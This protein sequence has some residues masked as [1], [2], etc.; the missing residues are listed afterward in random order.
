VVLPA[1]G[2]TP[3]LAGIAW[4]YFTYKPSDSDFD[5]VL[6]SSNPMDIF[7]NP[8]ASVETNEFNNALQ[9]KKQSRFILRSKALPS[10]RGGF[11]VALRVNGA[12]F[13][14]NQYYQS[15]VLYSFKQVTKEI[16]KKEES[17]VDWVKD[18]WEQAVNS[19]KA[20]LTTC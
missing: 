18:T 2:T 1:N 7:I 17:V 14:T 5:F 3:A 13:Y 10:L 8:G 11:T 9:A 4:L 16:P 19:V 6:S 15:K 12:N 20:A